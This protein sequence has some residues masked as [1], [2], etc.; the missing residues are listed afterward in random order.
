[1]AQTVET[2]IDYHVSIQ[3][4]KFEIAQLEARIVGR[5]LEVLELVSRRDTTLKNWTA[6]LEAIEHK[7]KTLT[8]L[9]AAHGVVTN[10]IIENAK[11]T[12]LVKEPEVK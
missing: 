3:K 12:E 5:Q 1:M 11:T 6:E 9:E 10:E 2:G 4:I 8:D 7:K